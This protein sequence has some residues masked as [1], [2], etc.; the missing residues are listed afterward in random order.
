MSEFDPNDLTF[1]P[2][3]TPDDPPPDYLDP[4]SKIGLSERVVEQTAPIAN[5]NPPL[6]DLVVIDM[7]ERD[8][9]GRR[10]YKTPLQAHNG[11][12]ALIDAYQKAL[13]LCVY[14]RQLIYERDEK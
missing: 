2:D 8:E 10:K 4:A 13:D 5:Q 6:W 7:R 1:N 14:M 3:Y 12:D 9:M 11:R